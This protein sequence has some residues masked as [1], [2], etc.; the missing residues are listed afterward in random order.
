M[1]QDY[2]SNLEAAVK[3]IRIY[4]ERKMFFRNFLLTKLVNAENAA[5]KSQKFGKLAV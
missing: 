3:H 4:F 2:L 5:Y 1:N